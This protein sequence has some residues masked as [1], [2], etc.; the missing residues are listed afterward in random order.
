MIPILAPIAELDDNTND[1]APSR[2][3]IHNINNELELIC[4]EEIDELEIM[5]DENI[6]LNFRPT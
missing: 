6:E 1:N 4:E 5:E 2:Q 3:S